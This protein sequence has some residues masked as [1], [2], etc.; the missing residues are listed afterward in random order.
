M[1]NSPNPSMYPQLRD[2]YHGAALAAAQA[3]RQAQGYELEIYCVPDDSNIDVAASSPFEGRVTVPPQSY[4]WAIAASSNQ[5]AG[6]DLQIRDAFAS[7]EFFGQ[8]IDWN[9]ASGQGSSQGMSSPLFI[10]P[11]P[12]LILEPGLL[13]VQI[14]NKAAAVNTIQV[15]L[16]IARPTKR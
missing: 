16:F 15:A 5:A 11:K 9:N 8:R 3:L 10:L 1:I 12:W 2:R 7:Q 6:F 14:F 4:V 13:I